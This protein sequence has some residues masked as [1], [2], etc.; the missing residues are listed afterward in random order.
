MYSWVGAYELLWKSN[1]GR[2]C[3]CS[4]TIRVIWLSEINSM[5]VNTVSAEGTRLPKLERL[6]RPSCGAFCESSKKEDEEEGH[7]LNDAII[8]I[9]EEN[10]MGF[11]LKTD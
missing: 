5:S 6:S 8:E 1:A 11:S 7:N 3:N 9:S 4:L 2:A 10:P